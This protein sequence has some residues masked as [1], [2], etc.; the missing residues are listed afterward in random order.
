MKEKFSD[1]V[2]SLIDHKDYNGAIKLLANVNSPRATDWI[3]RIEALQTADREQNAFH[4]TQWLL[5][6]IL[7]CALS[8]V[9]YFWFASL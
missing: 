6:S 5:L 9:L 7:F 2:Q 1:K 4:A 8:C 3:R